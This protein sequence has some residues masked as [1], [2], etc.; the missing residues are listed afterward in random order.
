M[1]IVNS[2]S[3]GKTSSFMAVHF[4]ADHNLFAVVC[5][6]DPECRV[7]DPS[8][9]RYAQDKLAAYSPEWGE[10]SGTAE[11]DLTL[12]AMRDLEQIMGQE[13]VWVRGPSFDTLLAGR[14][15]R[16]PSWARRYCTADMKIAPIAQWVFM[17]LAAPTEA[18]SPP[19]KKEVPY[20]YKNTI[21]NV[22]M[23]IGLRADEP[24]RVWRMREK[25]DAGIFNFPICQKIDT[26]RHTNKKMLYRTVRM[27]LADE[28]IK[29]RDVKAYWRGREI[30]FPEVSNCVGCFHKAAPV[31]N[32]Q[33]AIEPEK[34]RWFANAEKLGMGTWHDTR[35]T[36][37]AISR[38]KFTGRLPL[39]HDLY[40]A[41]DTGGC[42]D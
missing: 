37:D 18:I 40:S 12:A 33:F 13:I 7:K 2:L 16:L 4:P 17:N 24:N 14:Q 8:L 35:V 36:Y 32:A 28:G 5:L 27:P 29:N 6:D 15:T 19:K 31:I 26:R 41:C 25:A 11:S 1:K 39:D 22:E 38:M 42:T 23:R 21:C 30:T 9:L 10:F 20:G 3:G 34:M